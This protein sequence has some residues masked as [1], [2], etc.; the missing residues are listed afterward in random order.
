MINFNCITK[1]NINEHNPNGSQFP[2]HPYKIL[3]IGGSESGKTNALLNLINHKL[4]TDKIYLYGKK[5]YVVKY[6]QF[7]IK[8]HKITNFVMILKILLNT[9]MI[10]VI[11]MKILKNTIQTKNTKY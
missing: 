7:L 5:P 2:D 1:E 4:Y 11:F 9:Q 8:K 3:I 6:H 10:W